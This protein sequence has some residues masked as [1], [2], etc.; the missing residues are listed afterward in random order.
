LNRVVTRRASLAVLG[1]IATASI[2]LATAAKFE[3][4]D[5][6]LY[7][8]LT[9]ADWLLP[10]VIGVAVGLCLWLATAPRK[11]EGAAVPRES[12]CA[13]CGRPVLDDWRLCPE[14][15]SLIES[16]PR[17]DERVSGESQS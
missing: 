2:L 10:A 11:S 17:D 16:A 4:A 12:A 14:C 3:D 15:G 7:P 6:A 9:V 1:G 8:V 5:W 13:N